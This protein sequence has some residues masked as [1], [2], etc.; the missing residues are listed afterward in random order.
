MTLLVTSTISDRSARAGSSR[1]E[2]ARLAELACAVER[3]A[4]L[5][6]SAEVGAAACAEA[7]IRSGRAKGEIILAA[8]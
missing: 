1:H 2:T 5:F 7:G 8:E 6:A 4:G 3:E